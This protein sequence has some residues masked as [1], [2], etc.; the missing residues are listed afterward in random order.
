MN[1]TSIHSK[2]RMPVIIGRDAELAQLRQCLTSVI[3][4]QASPAPRFI[5]LRGNSGV[6]KSAIAQTTMSTAAELG[7]DVCRVACE[8]FH[9]GMSFFPIREL[10]RQLLKGKTLGEEITQIFGSKS[11]QA[12]MA[13]VSESVTADPVSRLRGYSSVVLKHNLRRF[14]LA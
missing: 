6:G 9:E 11:P 3:T 4:D 14:L 7:Y 8:P 13:S 2:N 1:A 12:V 5:L 10:V